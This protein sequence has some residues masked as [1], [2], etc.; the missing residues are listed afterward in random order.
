MGDETGGVQDA[1]RVR[2]AAV[3]KVG[4]QRRGKVGTDVENAGG[5][6]RG[7]R[8]VVGE[9]GDRVEPLTSIVIGFLHTRVLGCRSYPRPDGVQA[10]SRHACSLLDCARRSAG[11]AMHRRLEAGP[12]VH[13]HGT[14]S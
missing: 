14:P 11:A 12:Y 9:V 1:E 5:T 8:W 7:S 3:D 10:A 6:T 4:E 2:A 13:A